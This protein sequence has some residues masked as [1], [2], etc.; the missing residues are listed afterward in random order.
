MEKVAFIIDGGFFAKKYEQLN[1]KSPT[2]DD[3]EKYTQ[4]ILD[5]LNKTYPHPVAIYRIFYYDCPPLHNLKG[6]VS[7]PKSLS[8]CDFKSI[9]NSGSSRESVDL[10]ALR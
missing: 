3:I 1:K 4:N 2:A 7:K 6:L 10:K 8:D 9:S 5:F